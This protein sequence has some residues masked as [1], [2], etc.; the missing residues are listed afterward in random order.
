MFSLTT[1]LIVAGTAFIAGGLLS[2]LLNRSFSSSEQKTRTLET[3]LQHAE[4]SLADY[5]EEVT[6]HFAETAQ[7]VNNLTQ[8][9]KEVHQHLAG[10]ALKLANVDISRQLLANDLSG[11]NLSDN[12]SELDINPDAFQPPKD[13]APSEGTLSEG[14]GLAPEETPSANLDHATE[15]G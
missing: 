12:D 15:K 14:Y 9:Y 10:S 3:R 6:E 1:M 2:L 7:L 11:D 8:N 4:E 13:W 5:Q